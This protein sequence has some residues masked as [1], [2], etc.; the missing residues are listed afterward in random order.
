[1][2]RRKAY[3]YRL[4]TTGEIEGKFKQFA[5][6]CRF[7]W[8][9]VW[10]INQERLA[11]SHRI[12]TY[13]ESAFWLKLWKSSD[14]FEFLRDCHS[15]CLQQKLK[16][17]ER[18]YFDGFDKSQLLKRLPKVRRKGLHD[19]FRYPQG[20]KFDNRRVYLPKIGWVG[21]YKSCPI[22]GTVKNVT[23]SRHGNHWYIS[24]QVEK[25]VAEVIHPSTSAVGVDLGVKN[26]V[27]LSTGEQ[28]LPLSS[29]RYYEKKLAK[30]QQKLSRQKRYSEG[31]KKQKRKIRNIHS[32]IANA[33]RDFLHKCSTMLSK[34]HAMIVVEDLKI[35]Q[36]SKSAKG[37]VEEPGRQVKAKSGLNKSI[38]D[39]GWGEFCR[40][41]EYKLGWSGGE[42]I[43]VN[44]QYTSQ[45]CSICGETAKENRPDQSTFCC[46]RC[47][48]QD[49]ADI[50]AAK[51]ILAAGHAVLACGSN[52]IVGRKQELLGKGNLVPA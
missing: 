28:L 51:N 40:Q 14:D 39:Q 48:H 43:K 44:P 38:L 12:I 5:G 13:Q 4:K 29:F 2:E 45:R 34:S 20:V 24:V 17:L 18:A 22:D 7:V 21:F 50:N 31:W 11:N 23:V 42:L 9:K 19:S 41:L 47:G 26:F 30:A 37:S 25:E 49:H 16:D 8:N 46:R 33:R 10:T 27:T 6:C 35:R 3:R 32:D 15:Q 1:M 52:P 36:M